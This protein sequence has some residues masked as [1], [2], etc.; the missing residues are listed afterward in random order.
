MAKIYL[1]MYLS[2]REHLLESLLNFTVLSNY[3]IRLVPAQSPQ[4]GSKRE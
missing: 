1:S 3:S 2:V 4:D